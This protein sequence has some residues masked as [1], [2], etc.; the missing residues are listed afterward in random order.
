MQSTTTNLQPGTKLIFETIRMM[1]LNPLFYFLWQ[2]AWM[3]GKVWYVFFHV[4]NLWFQWGT[5][6]MNFGVLLVLTG[7]TFLLRPQVRRFV[8]P[9]INLVYSF[10]LFA[11]TLY[12]RYF[13]DFISI[14]VLL[15]V[16]QLH[17]I[18]GSVLALIK[19]GDLLF[20]A[21]FLLMVLFSYLGRKAQISAGDAV[22][23]RKVGIF[24]GSTVLG[25][26]PI[27]YQLHSIQESTPALLTST[28]SHM[29]V[30]NQLGV[31]GY[32]IQ[33]LEQFMINDLFARKRI[34]TDRKQ[35]IVTWFQSKQSQEPNEADNPLFGI[36]QGKNVIVIQMESVQNWVIGKSINHEEITPNLNKLIKDS[37]YF[38]NYYRQTAQG[39]TA[40]AEFLSLNSLYPIDTGSVYFRFVNNQYYSLPKILADHGYTTSAHVAFDPTFWNRQAM[41]KVEGIQSFEGVNEYNVDETFGLGLTDASFFRQTIAKLQKQSSPYFSF[42]ITLSSHGPFDI[43][44]Q[45]QTMDIGNLKGTMIGNYIESVHYTDAAIGKFMDQLRATGILD[46]SVVVLYGDHDNGIAADDPNYDAV[47]NLQPADSLGWY[48]EMKVP[49][50]IRLPNHQYAGVYNQTKGELDLTPTLLHLVGISTKGLPYMGQDVTVPDNQLVVFRDNSF[51][52]GRYFF[53][54]ND[55]TFEHGDCYDIKTGK[56]IDKMTV[57]KEYDEAKRQLSISDDILKGNLLPD[58]KAQLE[59]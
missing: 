51:T 23:K 56:K 58:L 49:L 25:V 33:D 41:Y 13:H 28:Y 26:I 45:Y 39:R 30:A 16:F 42:L 2:I 21:D 40:D 15:E 50:I 52:D 3:Y 24:L 11:D 57:R 38:P 12:F 36:A 20:I 4:S 14:P 19:P 34:N 7:W 27:F 47:M 37:M 46:Q 55:G 8:L 53:I 35:E 43:P 10:V 6:S 29:A 44:D 5:I 32:H 48:K 22:T 1:L 59:K 54:T 18:G 31:V 17:E 9:A